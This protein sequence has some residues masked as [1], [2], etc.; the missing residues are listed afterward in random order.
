MVN[1]FDLVAPGWP[2][3]GINADEES[4]LDAFARAACLLASKT[5]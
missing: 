3:E 1:T 4:D 5:Q 2:A